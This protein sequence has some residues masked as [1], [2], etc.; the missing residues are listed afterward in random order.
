MSTYRDYDY[1]DDDDDLADRVEQLED[2][3]ATLKA[4]AVSRFELFATIAFAV[5]LVTYLVGA[6]R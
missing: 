5:F 4:K 3:L 2:A 1:D 6:S